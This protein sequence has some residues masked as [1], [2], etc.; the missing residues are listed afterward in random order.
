MKYISRLPERNAIST[1][2]VE[3]IDTTVYVA[4]LTIFQRVSHTLAFSDNLHS[5][6]QIFYTVPCCKKIVKKPR[7][8]YLTSF[9][10]CEDTLET[11]LGR[12]TIRITRVVKVEEATFVA[13]KGA[14][15]SVR[16]MTLAKADQADSVRSSHRF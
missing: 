14:L 12:T 2:G 10:S 1:P 3:N 11:L 7:R 6:K 4:I 13:E 15:A 5:Y 8:R 9:L 16:L